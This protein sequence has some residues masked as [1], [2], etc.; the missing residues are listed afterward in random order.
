MGKIKT[1]KLFF[2]LLTLTTIFASWGS[3][4]QFKEPKYIVAI[5]WEQA[6]SGGKN[7]P[8]VT[9]VFRFDC[10]T[11]YG[12]VEGQLKTHYDAYYKSNRNTMYLKDE[13]EFSYDNR[14]DADK[15]RTELIAKFKNN[16]N[17]VLLIDRFSVKCD[18]K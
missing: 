2:L 13:L 16:G 17:D 7:Q 10:E 15:K 14:A 6:K 4:K 18:D 5:A 12:L 9:N 8:I 1:I 3:K 11:N